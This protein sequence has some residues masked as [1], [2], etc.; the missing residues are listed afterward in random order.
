MVKIVSKKLNIIKKDEGSIF[1]ILK[2]TSDFFEGFG[3]V[4]ISSIK[5]NV[6]RAWKR[7]KNSNQYFVVPIGEVKFVFLIENKNDYHFKE[8]IIGEKN[9]S[10][11]K[12]PNNVWYGFK[13][14]SN[15]TSF[16]VNVIDKPYSPEEAESLDIDKFPFKGYDW[17]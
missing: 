17:K 4:Y 12:I 10:F 2:S 13:N 9:Y 3:E 6:L 11:I 1:P 5:S 16:I 14:I 7:H 15:N 8:V